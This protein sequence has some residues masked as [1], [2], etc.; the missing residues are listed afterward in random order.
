ME[1]NQRDRVRKGWGVIRER[2]SIEK[3]GWMSYQRKKQGPL[4]EKGYNQLERLDTGSRSLGSL[5]IEKG[6]GYGIGEG[7][8]DGG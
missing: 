2:S 3:E 5:E 6:R 8:R 7:G 1:D 4:R